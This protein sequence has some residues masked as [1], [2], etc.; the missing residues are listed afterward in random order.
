MNLELVFLQVD[1]NSSFMG[2]ISTKIPGT[3]LQISFNTCI[4]IF[5]FPGIYISEFLHF[6]VNYSSFLF[7]DPHMQS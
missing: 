6:S 1:F 3:F 2:T 5:L 7:C 4:Y